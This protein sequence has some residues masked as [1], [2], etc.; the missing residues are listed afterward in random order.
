MGDWLGT[1][2]CRINSC[3]NIAPSKKRATSFAPCTQGTSVE[4]TS[5][6]QRRD[7]ARLAR[8]LRIFP[9]VQIRSYANKGW[10]G[11]GDWLGTGNVATHLREYRP[12]RK[13]AIL[14]PQARTQEPNR[15]EAFRKGEMP[16]I[17][18]IACGYSRNP[19]VEPISRQGLGGLGRLA[20]NGKCRKPAQEYRPFR[21]SPDHSSED[22]AQELNRMEKHSVKGKMPRI[23]ELPAD[24]PTTPNQ[25]YKRQG[26]GWYGRLAGHGNDCASTQKIPSLS[27]E[28]A[29]LCSEA[30]DSKRSRR[31]EGVLQRQDA[32]FG[33][34]YLRTFPQPQNC[35][36]RRQGLG[37]YGR[38][39][40][41]RE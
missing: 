11:W 30:S 7:A 14:C 17:G 12:F 39:A 22:S 20:G 6:L 37:W 19:L 2:E 40:G 15:M 1:R 23:G 38:L 28:L 41:T 10:A 13:G 9:L 27:R 26:L 32:A 35:I 21:R 3:E 29:I 25:K 34:H 36:I 18:A 33:A 4:W 24:I 5:L 8:C 16:A 31:M